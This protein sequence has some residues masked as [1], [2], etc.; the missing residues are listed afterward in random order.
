MPQQPPSWT[1]STPVRPWMR[2]CWQK[3]PD[4]AGQGE[5]SRSSPPGGLIETSGAAVR[6]CQMAIRDA[7]MQGCPMSWPDL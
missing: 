7:N 1:H 5:R 4:D 2:W 6:R 3:Y